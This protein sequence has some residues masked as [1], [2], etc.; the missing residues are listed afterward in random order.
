M[1]KIVPYL[2]LEPKLMRLL[3][4]QSKNLPGGKSNFIW[5]YVLSFSLNYEKQFTVD[6]REKIA[7][8]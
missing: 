8:V 6:C 5:R 1:N 3:Q 2:E 4:K 7:F